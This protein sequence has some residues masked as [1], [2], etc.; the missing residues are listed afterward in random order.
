[1]M[2]TFRTVATVK[3]MPIIA[4]VESP[5]KQINQSYTTFMD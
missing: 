3:A 5:V 4:P 1:M 2:T